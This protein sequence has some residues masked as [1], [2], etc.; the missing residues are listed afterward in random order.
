MVDDLI[1]FTRP[2]WW[3]FWRKPLSRFEA[4]SAIEKGLIGDLEP[5]R[6]FGVALDPVVELPKTF[7]RFGRQK[8]RKR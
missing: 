5:L 4:L 1:E 6:R 7:G 8:K 3:K 2:P